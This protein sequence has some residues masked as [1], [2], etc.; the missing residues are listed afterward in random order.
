MDNTLLNINSIQPEQVADYARHTMLGSGEHGLCFARGSGV[1]LF[2]ISGKSYLDCTSQG[3]A[4]LLGHAN[5]EI[6]QAVYEQM[7]EL[8]HLS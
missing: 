3:W 8:G 2:D 7:G 4:L 6:R 5:P 1:R